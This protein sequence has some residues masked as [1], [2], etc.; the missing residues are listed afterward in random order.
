M[1]QGLPPTP[2]KLFIRAIW[3]LLSPGSL[4]RRLHSP[5]NYLNQAVLEIREFVTFQVVRLLVDIKY[6]LF[7]LLSSHK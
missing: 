2:H 3:C 6:S 4:K 1:C 7:L 5:V